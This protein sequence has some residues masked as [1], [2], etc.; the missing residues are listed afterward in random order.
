MRI[1]SGFV[2]ETVGD[3]V[4]AV[5]VGARAKEFSGFVRLNKSGAYFWNLLAD[6]DKT[7]A[8]LVDAAMK[9]F[10][11]VERSLVESDVSRFVKSL[12]DGGIIEI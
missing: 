6:G 3:E 12:I 10:V 2:L 8:E 5:A 4:L 11:D 7:E 9:D 1:K